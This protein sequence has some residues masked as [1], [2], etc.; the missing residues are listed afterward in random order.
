M[1]VSELNNSVYVQ[2][3]SV[4]HSDATR[5]PGHNANISLQ[6][7]RLVY[8]TR[9][10]TIPGRNEGGTMGKGTLLDQR[11]DA[12]VLSAQLV[13]IHRPRTSD[14]SNSVV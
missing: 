5:N 2:M 12:L 7:Q 3:S 6:R 1:T 4:T 14:Y 11:Y 9:N 13:T 10:K 8:Y